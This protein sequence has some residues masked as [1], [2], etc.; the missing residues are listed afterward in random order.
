MN[1]DE[2]QRSESDL[3]T[4]VVQP[5]PLP[6]AT[7]IRT[8]AQAVLTGKYVAPEIV[9]Q[10]LAI[11]RRCDKRRVTPTGVEWCGICGCKVAR[12]DRQ[13]NNLAA[14]EENLPKWGCKH[15]HRREGKGWPIPAVIE[16]E[17]RTELSTAQ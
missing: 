5:R 4:P 8:F 14:Y 6:G 15:P 9:A 1:S 7:Q 10:R 11:C 3:A 13:I 2:I 12:K 17:N 16:S